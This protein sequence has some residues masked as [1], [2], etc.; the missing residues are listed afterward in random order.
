M[1]Y[2]ISFFCFISI[3]KSRAGGERPPATRY[4]FYGLHIL[5]DR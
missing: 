4:E 5:Q 3:I 2:E 1:G